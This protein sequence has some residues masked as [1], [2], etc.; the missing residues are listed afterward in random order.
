[1]EFNL[2]F[3]FG[4]GI[5]NAEG[6]AWKVQS[7]FIIRLLSQLGMG[8]SDYEMTMQ[9]LMDNLE[10]YIDKHNG[11]AQDFENVVFLYT[12][13]V[14]SELVW[15]KTYKHSDKDFGQI[16]NWI[17]NIFSTLEHFNLHLSGTLFKYYLKLT[18][19]FEKRIHTNYEEFKNYV[20][21]IVDEREKHFE[22]NNCKDL[23][24]F[25]LNECRNPSNPYISYDTVA[26][27]VAE[28]LMD[29]SESTN[30]ILYSCLY[31]LT[32]N[33]NVQQ[34]MFRE[35]MDTIGPDGS[36][37]YSDRNRLPYTQAVIAEVQRYIIL[38][39]LASFHVS[40]GKKKL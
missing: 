10:N 31:L 28:L 11:E 25:W 37:C 35:I 2:F 26:T 38:A 32:V 34:K 22:S 30:G 7:K 5:G 24:D 33:Q 4:D 6:E 40:R 17:W 1:T 29:G 9:T 36:F 19:D 8:K 23:L 12:F 18:T 3:I 39:P 13:N 21:R 15:S 16:R 20:K 27:N 14:V